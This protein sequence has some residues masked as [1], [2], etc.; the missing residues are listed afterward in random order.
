MLST[1]A[2]SL[3]GVG[4]THGRTR[5]RARYFPSECDL[6]AVAPGREPEQRG[7]ARAGAGEHARVAVAQPGHDAPA[8]ERCAPEDDASARGR[9]RPRPNRKRP[10]ADTRVGDRPAPLLVE[11]RRRRAAAE[12]VRA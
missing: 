4:V 2:P 8:V 9:V 11:D 5:E 12:A 7:V 3:A 10:A 6:A 1:V